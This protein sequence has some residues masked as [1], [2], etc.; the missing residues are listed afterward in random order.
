MI[1]R[2]F[3]ALAVLS[4][5]AAPAPRAVAEGDDVSRVFAGSPS[6]AKGEFSAWLGELVK[7]AAAN[8]ASPYA[9]AALTK[10]E[11]L[12]GSADDPAV[13]EAALDPLLARGIADGEVDEKVRD[14]LCARAR[15]RGDYDKAKSYGQNRGY[16]RRFAVTGPFG[17]KD[18]TLVHRKFAPEKRDLDPAAAMDGLWGPVHWM[19]LHM[20]GDSPWVSAGEQVRRGEGVMYG[21][22]RVKS[23]TARTVALKV[24]CSD[25]FK[26]FVNSNPVLVADRERD[27]VPAETWATARLEAGANR[28]LVKVAGSDPFAIKLCD[29]ATGLPVLDVE[30]TDPLAAGDVPASTGDAEPRTYRSP[31]E[32]ALASSRGDAAAAIAAG[33]VADLDGREW[34]AY[35]A[36]ESA[37]AAVGEA[38]SVLSANVHAAYGRFLAGFGELPEVERKLRAKEQFAAAVKA[39]PTH[40]SAA[41]RL[42]QYENDDDHP[43]KALKAL[44]EQVKAQ[45]TAT[46]WM[47]IARIA[48]AREFEREAIDAAENALKAS[49]N[50]AEAL[51]FLLEFDQKYANAQAAAARTKR[52]LEIDASDEGAIS[53]SIGQLRAQGKHEEALALVRTCAARWP[54]SL[55][56]RSQAASLLAALGRDAEALGELRELAKLVP[57]EDDYPRTIA[58][59]LEGKGDTAGAIENYRKSL[60]LEP[61]QPAVWRALGRLEGT[62]TDF[63][64]PF[65]P[66]TEDLV[67]ALPSTE[68]LKKRYPKAV[69][70]TVLDHSVVRVRPDGT[71]QS[72]VHMVWK[73]LDE[74]AVKKYSIVRRAGE[75][76]DV[77]ATLP[78]GRVMTPTGIPG[79]S[80]NMEGLV[81]GALVEHRYLDN[82]G[83]T[84][85]GYDGGQFLFQDND[86]RDEPNPVLLS[87]YVVI[88]PES[89]KLDPVKR[90]YEGDPKVETKDGARVTVWEKRDMPRIEPERYM[91]DALEFIPHVDY[92]IPESSEDVNWRLLARRR[93]SRVTPLLA[94]AAAKA[95]KPGM[96]D[97]DKLHALYDWVNDTITGDD[98]GAEGPTATLIQ[99]SGDRSLLFEALVRAA[100]VPYEHG[101]A[102]PWNG[103][104]RSGPFRVDASSFSAPFLLLE[105]AGAEP[106]AFVMAG[107]LAPF[108]LLPESYRGSSAWIAG[109]QGG[110]IIRL[111][112]G[113]PN[114][115][116]S[117][118][119]DIRL[120]ADPAKTKVAG[121]LVYRGAEDYDTKKGVVEAPQDD[122]R[123]WAESTF[124]RY[125]ASPALDGVE[126]PGLET[127]G[128]AFEMRL[129]GSMS[130]YVQAQGASY[131]VSLGLPKINMSQRFI[132]R[133]ER[134]YDLVINVRDDRMEEFTI[135]LGDAFEVRTL[136]EDHVVFH[137][138][139]TYSL[140]WREEGGKVLVRREAHLNPAR[141]RADEYKTLVAWCKA[142][143]DAE[144]RKLELRKVR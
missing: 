10:T 15:A 74:K 81:P 34:E 85:K 59:I 37:A 27:L 22:A 24:F 5:L 134:T 82:H 47:A 68:E 35:Q 144:E 26:V 19:P 46:A 136:P 44:R 105:P 88:T 90:N 14:L 86:F 70:I 141:Y 38:D 132:E 122:R 116:D 30:E 61:F 128:V 101:R 6:E 7:A 78:D 43:D 4:L 13:V 11:A 36:F 102:M 3:V 104:G 28:L 137:R 119:F 23:A 71:S 103:Q 49:K 2:A 80:Y 129:A 106:V 135:D 48:K 99:K 97:L 1:R 21:L 52:L 18:G 93:N 33:Y 109:E 57:M 108:G 75:L 87:R 31:I 9:H 98:G 8:P 69:A 42:A 107:R 133:A 118:S 123:K 66:A 138:L 77:H 100:G 95:V 117:A 73:L 67:K 121:S 113:G 143:D 51:R 111:P 63:G 65:E 62:E 58:T 12:M 29:P 25:S 50:D 96:S 89:M 115:T 120:S 32:R 56:W 39:L 83:T 126:F 130:N 72:Y 53:G 76:L 16:L 114:V 142:I 17:W 124:S 112:S 94:D 54:G 55:G 92:S 127:R 79:A 140:T 41:V 60:A 131:V 64:A 20:L 125:F 45:P 139:G 110:R 91:P 40:N 84:P